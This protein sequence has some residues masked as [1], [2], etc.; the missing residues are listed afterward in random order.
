[1][2]ERVNVYAQLGMVV[3]IS[4]VMTWRVKIIYPHNY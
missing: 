4:L 2:L 1:M 3:L